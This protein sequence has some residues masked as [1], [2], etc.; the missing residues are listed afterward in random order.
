MAKPMNFEEAKK[1][2]AEYDTDGDGFISL[3]GT[4]ISNYLF[5]LTKP[6]FNFCLTQR[7]RHGL[8]MQ[9]QHGQR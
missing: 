3:Q 2:F 7:I 1:A 9:R 8:P 4:L 6:N 5:L